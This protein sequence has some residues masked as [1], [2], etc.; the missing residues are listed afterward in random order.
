MNQ[1]VRRHRDILERYR[2]TVTLHVTG[3][4]TDG[5]TVDLTT[6]VTWSSG[7]TRVAT[8][9]ANGVVTGVAK[10]ATIRASSAGLTGVSFVIVT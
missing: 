9:S 10:G 5:S 7:N 2:E 8:I 4:R 1:R 3:V 6:A